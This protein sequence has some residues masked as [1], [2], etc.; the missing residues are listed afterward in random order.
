MPGKITTFTLPSGHQVAGENSRPCQYSLVVW[1]GRKGFRLFEF[2]SNCLVVNIGPNLIRTFLL[3]AVL[4]IIPALAQ[5]QFTFTTNNGAITITG[6]TG[7]GG[8]T[9]IPR[10]INGYPVKNIGIFAFN[11]FPSP[12]VQQN[13]VT[14]LVIP[15]SV[16]NIGFSA[17]YGCSQLTNVV[18]STNVTVL[19]TEVFGLTGLTTFTFPSGLTNIGIGAFDSCMNLTNVLIPNGVQ[20]I[21]DYAFN[22]NNCMNSVTIPDSVTS[23]GDWSFSG[24]INIT[25]LTIGNGITTIPPATFTWCTK[26]TTVSIPDSVTNIGTT[27]YY[28]AFSDCFALTN[29]TYGSGL[30]L[31]VGSIRFSGT[32]NLSTITV[33]PKNPVLSSLNGVLFDKNQTTLIQCP[34]GKAGSYIIPNTV[35]SIWNQAFLNCSGLTDVSL[36]SSIASSGGN[37]FNGCTGITNITLLDGVTN[38]I[39][40]LFYACVNLE[41]FTASPGN[42]CFS[43]VNGVLFDKNQT[44]LVQYPYNGNQSYTVPSGIINIADN[45]FAECTGLTHL[46]LSE[47]LTGIGQYAFIDCSNLDTIVIPGSVTNIGAAAFGYCQLLNKIYFKGNAPTAD[48][49]VFIYNPPDP[50]GSWIIPATVYYLPG[51]AGWSNSFASEPTALWLPEIQTDTSLGISSNGF[52]FSINW[53]SGQTIVIVASTNLLNPFWSPVATNTFTSGT[54]YFNDPKWTNYTGRYYHVRSP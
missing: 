15:D 18:M 21:G 47:G 39:L 30:G 12:Y 43:S 24:C 20:Y 3:C 2:V 34:V 16:T 46:V 17:F 40:G 14:S 23:L 35:T 44:T 42:P 32:T 7:S 48:D 28:S 6:Y 49:S 38:S 8:S 22:G 37:N 27:Y 4:L 54:A 13:Q 50:L 26:L 9:V 11:P 52:G 31:N 33:S 29:I 25:N 19:A 1:S 10:V 53:A 41:S 51:A 36:S 5:A 45:A